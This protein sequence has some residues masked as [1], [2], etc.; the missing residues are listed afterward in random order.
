MVDNSES[1]FREIAAGNLLFSPAEWL[2]PD[3]T[4]SGSLESQHK[5]AF[6]VKNEKMTAT[7]GCSHPASAHLYN[8]VTVTSLTWFPSESF[9]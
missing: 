3:G 4:D 7:G 8:P 9:C 1:D 2:V 6:S 5:V